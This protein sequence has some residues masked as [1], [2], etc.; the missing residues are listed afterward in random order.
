M[1]GYQ[2]HRRTRQRSNVPEAL[3]RRV[4]A[5]DGYRCQIGSD[6]CTGDADEADHIIPDGEGGETNLRNLQAA[7]GPC[8][9]LKTQ[10]EA[11]RA[12]RRLGRKR[13]PYPHPGRG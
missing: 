13:R 10:D 9:A 7:C 3:R 8:H 6:V 5:R 2:S 4:F 1:A 11:Q 12:R